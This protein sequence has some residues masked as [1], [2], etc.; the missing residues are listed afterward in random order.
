[1][2]A[3][4]ARGGT[5]GRVGTVSRGPAVTFTPV[6]Q[7]LTDGK[8]TATATFSAP[9]VYSLMAVV[10]DGSGESAGNFGYHC[11]WTNVVVKV[12]VN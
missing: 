4:A 3:A 10:D 12:I 7:P 1:M 5:D 11:C 2:A 9:G 6:K 8:A